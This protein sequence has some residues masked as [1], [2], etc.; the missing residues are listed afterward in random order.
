[1]EQR[2]SARAIV[3]DDRGNVILIHRKWRGRE[4]WVTPGGGVEEGESL[5]DAVRRELK[6]EVGIDVAVGAMV[7]E[8]DK[9]VDGRRSIQKFFACEKIAGVI[10][11]GPDL[12]STPDD[13]S[14]V[15]ALTADEVE[16]SNV[17]PEEA[18]EAILRIMRAGETGRIL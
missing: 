8:V 12:R 7:L 17:V 1:M 15:V 18:K 10:G 16:R 6:E 2:T 13:Y 11:N 3:F 5:E 9:E 14:A 4:Y